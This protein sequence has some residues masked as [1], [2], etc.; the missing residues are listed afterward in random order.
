MKNTILVIGINH[1][2]TAIGQREKIYSGENLYNKLPSPLFAEKIVLATYNRVE[3]YVITPDL[4]QAIR[5]LKKIFSGQKVY[6]YTNQ[7]AVKHLFE[8]A[9]GIDSVI[10]G[11]SEILYQIKKA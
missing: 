4:R 3:I 8:V 5:F 10:L 9:S 7:Q 2:A 11:E 1:N 6:V